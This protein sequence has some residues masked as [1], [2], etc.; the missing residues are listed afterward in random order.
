MFF[1]QLCFRPLAK[2]VFMICYV[3]LPIRFNTS[4]TNL[5]TCDLAHVRKGC[6]VLY[7]ITASV[8]LY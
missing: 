3:Y 5:L 6:Q 8:K 2:S 1:V 7:H 4:V